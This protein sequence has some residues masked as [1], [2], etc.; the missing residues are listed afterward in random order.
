MRFAV[1]ARAESSPRESR[2]HL[3]RIAAEVEISVFGI[4]LESFKIW[5]NQEQKFIKIS[6]FGSTSLVLEGVIMESELPS[7]IIL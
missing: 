3:L 6:K 1:R 5:P 4:A 2:R 7:S